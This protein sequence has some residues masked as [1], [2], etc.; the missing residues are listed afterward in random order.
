MFSGDEGT[1]KTHLLNA[2]GNQ[3]RT[4]GWRVQRYY[5]EYL[6]NLVQ[7]PEGAQRIDLNVSQP[8]SCEVLILD[9]VEWVLKR[10]EIKD[11]VS[12]LLRKFVQAPAKLI[13]SSIAPVD[14]FISAVRSMEKLEKAHLCISAPADRTTLLRA[15]GRRKNIHFSDQAI[16]LLSAQL[17]SNA[18]FISGVILR[19]RSS[20]TSMQVQVDERKASEL[21]KTLG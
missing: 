11:S 21:L 19:F 15:F 4:Q 8:T 7:S 9:A 10:L 3:L 2:I 20:S 17:P 5:A 1:G 12:D 16:D 13:V 6:V 14:S 18:A